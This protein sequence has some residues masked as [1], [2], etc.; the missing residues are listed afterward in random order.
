MQM[1]HGKKQKKKKER[2]PA[3]PQP[4]QLEGSTHD[5]RPLD[6]S[7]G[8]AVDRIKEDGQV[9]EGMATHLR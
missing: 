2:T 6:R 1:L 7:T 3:K 8:E 4:Q 5:H 9:L